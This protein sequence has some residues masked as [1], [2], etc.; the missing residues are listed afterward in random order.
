MIRHNIIHLVL[1]RIEGAPAGIKGV[2]LVR[3]PKVLVMPTV[4][5]ARNRVSCELDRAQDGIHGNATCVMN[6]DSATGWLIGEENRHAGMFVMY[7]LGPLGRRGAGLAQSEVATRMPQLCARAPAGV[8]LGSK[9]P[10]KPRSEYRASDVRRVPAH[11]PRLHEAARAWWCDRAEE[12][13]AHR[14][15]IPR[16]PG[17]R[18]PHGPD[19][20]V[21]KGV[22]TGRRF[23]KPVMAQQMYGG[24]GY[25]AEH[26]WSIRARCAHRHA[27]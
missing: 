19:A 3:V 22:M 17:G 1:A 25:I 23:S 20:P 11:H 12:R 15:P 7:E 13:F 6:Y 4:R 24:H 27:L 26:G 10:D 5:G 14:S 8:R 9:A 2:S 21:M 16:S 18:R